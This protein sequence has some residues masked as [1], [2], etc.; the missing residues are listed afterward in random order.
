MRYGE[1]SPGEYGGDAALRQITLTT[2]R[3]LQQKEYI[4]MSPALLPTASS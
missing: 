2:H 1:R 3:A 4:L